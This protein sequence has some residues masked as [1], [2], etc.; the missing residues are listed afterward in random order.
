MI[1]KKR[2]IIIFTIITI[3][4]LIY[5]INGNKKEMVI[6]EEFLNLSEIEYLEVVGFDN[7]PL[8]RITD[9]DD[10]ERIILLLQQLNGSIE[11][12]H[13]PS[14]ESLL[15]LSI[16][17]KGHYPS[18]AIIIYQDKIIFHGQGRNISEELVNELVRTIESSF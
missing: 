8:I 5:S 10:V 17:L 14:D 9:R 6:Y 15:G 1:K 4:L 3:G 13:I 18:S 12:E 11:L 7:K 2:I 16:V